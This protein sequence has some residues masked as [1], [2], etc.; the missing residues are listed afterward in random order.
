MAGNF[1]AWDLKLSQ[2]NR[3]KSEEE[4]LKFIISFAVL[5]PSSHNSQPWKFKVRKMT[6]EVYFEQERSLPVG[7]PED[8]LSFISIGCALKNL[9]TAADYY[10]YKTQLKITTAGKS[11]FKPVA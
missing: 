7:D 6:I 11:T 5:A 8:R 3:L 4:K 2:F 10:G 9:I 1:K